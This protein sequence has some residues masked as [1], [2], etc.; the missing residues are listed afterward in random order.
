MGGDGSSWA[1]THG[2]IAQAAREILSFRFRTSNIRSTQKSRGTA[3]GGG[4][5][6][7]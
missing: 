1:K 6:E 4:G 2:F 5:S 7:E 3:S